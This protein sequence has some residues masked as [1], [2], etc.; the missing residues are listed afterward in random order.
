MISLHYTEK[1]NTKN[2]SLGHRWDHLRDTE[3]KRTKLR[4]LLHSENRV[5]KEAYQLHRKYVSRMQEC[6]LP[7]PNVL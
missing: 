5:D 7:E 4:D 2:V 1:K 3:T 6:K